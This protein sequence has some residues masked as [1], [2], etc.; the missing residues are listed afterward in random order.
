MSFLILKTETEDNSNDLE[1]QR[2]SSKSQTVQSLFM[3]MLYDNK[4]FFHSWKIWK[5]F[6]VR[7]FKVYKIIQN[8]WYT[9]IYIGIRMYARVSNFCVEHLRC[10]YLMLDALHDLLYWSINQAKKMIVKAFQASNEVIL[11]Q[12]FKSSVKVRIWPWYCFGCHF[13]VKV[14]LQW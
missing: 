5:T 8:C 13:K 11:V 10:L 14:L 2:S 12:F 3:D 9:Y 4:Y 7:V 1:E 6:C